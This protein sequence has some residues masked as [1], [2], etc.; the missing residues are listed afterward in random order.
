MMPADLAPSHA[1]HLCVK[2]ILTPTWRSPT[3]GAT[4]ARLMACVSSPLI[5]SVPSIPAT[6][7]SGSTTTPVSLASPCTVED[8]SD[9]A[10]I[11]RHSAGEL[12][13]R[14]R[15]LAFVTPS[16]ASS[17]AALM[18]SS[19]LHAVHYAAL[20]TADGTATHAPDARPYP[21]MAL[22]ATPSEARSPIAVASPTFPMTSPLPVPGAV[23]DIVA[24]TT[25]V[26]ATPSASA[27]RRTFREVRE[28][29][30]QPGRLSGYPP[31]TFPLSGAALAALTSPTPG[32][33]EEAA[34]YT[35]LLAPPPPP[36][37]EDAKTDPMAVTEQPPP[38]QPLRLVFKLAKSPMMPAPA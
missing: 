32:P 7:V 36:T 37:T 33:A 24:V 14:K 38:P 1:E 3:S 12:T 23:G 13:E 6:P 20:G 19:V 35:V 31:R 9:E 26:S 4:D 29:S 22:G 11:L 21:P 10:F 28:S 2:E 25:P 8:L 30:L 34:T 18:P 16:S 15:Y 5:A 17:V 27:R